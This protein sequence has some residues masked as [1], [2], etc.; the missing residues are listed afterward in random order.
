MTP[1][2]PARLRGLAAFLLTVLPACAGDP[3]APDYGVLRVEVTTAGGDLDSDGYLVVVDGAREYPLQPNG[4]L[5][6]PEIAAGSHVA[7]LTGIAANCAAIPAG[8]VPFVMRA[9]GS[10]RIGFYVSCLA[11]GL[12]IVT[13]STGPDVDL[14]GYALYGSYLT[15]DPVQLSGLPV[16]GT[17]TVT[18]LEPGPYALELRDVAN[19]CSVQDGNSRPIFVE[20][21]QVLRV[22]FSVTCL[23]ATAVIQVHVSTGGTDFD[24][25]YDLR[26][27]T[28]FG[29]RA[30]STETVS[31]VL[32][33][34][35]AYPVRL[36]DVAPNCVVEGDNPRVLTVATGGPVRDTA[37]TTFVVSCTAAWELAVERNGIELIAITRGLRVRLAAGVAPAWSP[38]G[39]RL[40]F[41]C[42]TLVCIQSFDGRPA[43]T[44]NPGAELSAEG[45]T[46]SPDGSTILGV[47]QE[48]YVGYYGYEYCLLAGFRLLPVDGAAPSK[49]SLPAVI[50]ASDPAW[51][52]DGRRVA[53][54]CL[55]QGG[56]HIRVCLANADGTGLTQLAL[57]VADARHPAWHPDGSRLVFSGDLIQDGSS[58]LFTVSAEGGTVTPLL[59]G[60]LGLQPTWSRDGSRIAFRTSFCPVAIGG[61]CTPGIAVVNSDGSGLAQL[62]VGDDNRPVWRP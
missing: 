31:A 33:G 3:A 2:S 39:Q 46:W 47:G 7:T 49:V 28:V 35:G 59:P 40:A 38:D 32:T 1:R 60:V 16:S 29:H 17:V 9:G 6:L 14:N 8:P 30:Q 19:N 53:F 61:T 11:T 55:F 21:G 41:L 57:A 48:C 10:I 34:G 20:P 44:L 4:S 54:T 58:R 42:G 62:T 22:T 27:G 45:L 25:G 50:Y 5:D 24:P 36:D 43:V 15:R 56:N 23:A 12:E 51:A 18:R 37:R 52:P 13:L 26:I